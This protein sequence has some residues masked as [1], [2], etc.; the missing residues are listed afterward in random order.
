[1]TTAIR[2]DLTRI[3]GFSPSQLPFKALAPVEVEAHVLARV[4]AGDADAV[5][6]LYD[7]HSSA[8]FGLALRVT[9]DRALAED[10]TQETFVGI[11][12]NAGRYDAGRGSIRTWIMAI[13]H[14]R[15]VDAVRRRRIAAL[16]LDD[17]GVADAV[18]SLPDVWP[19]V[20]ARFDAAAVARAF[21]KLSYV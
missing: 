19:E 15:A 2:G 4:A 1:M 8:I 21:A 3:A 18:P 7:L 16:S 14:N 17:V 10:A 12:K 6:E 5:S 13:A 20:S 11:W 9:N